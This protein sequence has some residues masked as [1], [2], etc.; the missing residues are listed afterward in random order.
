M[1]FLRLVGR[2]GA[3]GADGPHGLIS[4]DELR[5]VGGRDV[6]EANVHLAD[7]DF[8]ELA[9]VALL[10]RLA[11]A[12]DSRE[13]SRNRGPGAQ[14]DRLV[15]LAEVL[16]ALAV[17]DDDVLRARVEQHP[18][19]N[20]AGVRAGLLPVAVLSA[21][22]DMRSGGCR[23][24]GRH[25]DRR[26]AA[27]DLDVREILRAAVSDGLMFI[28]QLPAMI[29]FLIVSVTPVLDFKLF[30]IP[31]FQPFNFST[32]NFLCFTPAAL[33]ISLTLSMKA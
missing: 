20:L 14:V 2:S 1:D 29:F 11:D 21:N 26:R 5:A 32:V 13:A 24:C 28:F 31:T 33:N 9:G 25:V 7:N 8:L 10:E 4:D 19:R 15:R 18:S 12:D 23:D 30:E 17:A 6:L 27:H 16:A 3:A 22:A